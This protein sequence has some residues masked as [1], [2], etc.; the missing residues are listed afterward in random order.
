[1]TWLPG[2][3]PLCLAWLHTHGHWPIIPSLGKDIRIWKVRNDICFLPYIILINVPAESE[4]EE[5]TGEFKED[6][7]DDFEEDSEDTPTKRTRRWLEQRLLEDPASE[8]RHERPLEQ[9]YKDTKRRASRRFDHLYNQIAEDFK[10][11]MKYC[12]DKKGSR[13]K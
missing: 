9:N 3:K 8:G 11:E 2:K 12:K 5:E 10:A 7:Y 1:M 4:D 13:K 6:D